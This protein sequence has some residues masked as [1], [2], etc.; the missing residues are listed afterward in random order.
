MVRGAGPGWVGLRRYAIL[1][2][3]AGGEAE[4][5]RGGVRLVSINKGLQIFSSENNELLPDWLLTK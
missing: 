5:G 1:L 2:Y 4:G 3:V